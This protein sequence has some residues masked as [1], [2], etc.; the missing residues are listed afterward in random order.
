MNRYHDAEKIKEALL[1]LKTAFPNLSLHTHI[2]VGFPTE[3][4]KEFKQTLSFIKDSNISAGQL[5][6]FSRKSGAEA[7][8]IEPKISQDEIYKRLRYGKEFFK[9]L[10]YGVTFK[11]KGKVF[12]FDKMDYYI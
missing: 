4:D 5:N 2:I 12:L 7:E 3:T 6:I 8:N 9:N 11:A 1:R 10:E